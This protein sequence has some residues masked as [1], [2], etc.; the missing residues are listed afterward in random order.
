M[1][2]YPKPSSNFL[3]ETFLSTTP[4]PLR[5][6]E[7]Y[8]DKPVILTQRNFEDLLEE[9]LQKSKDFQDHPTFRKRKV[10]SHYLRRGQGTLC[11]NSKSPTFRETKEKTFKGPDRESNLK[12]MK[13]FPKAASHINT[14]KKL[15]QNSPEEC[16]KRIIQRPEFPEAAVVQTEQEKSRITPL[17]LYKLRRERWKTRANNENSQTPRKSIEKVAELIEDDKNL[18]IE[19]LRNQLVKLKESFR[20]QEN[21]WFHEKEAMKAQIVELQQVNLKLQKEL[22]LKSGKERFSLKFVEKYNDL[23]KQETVY[24]NGTKRVTYVNGYSV[25]FYSNRDVREDLLDGRQVYYFFESGT[26]QV[27]HSDGMKEVWFKNGQEERFLSNGVREIRFPDGSTK[28]VYPED[29]LA[30]LG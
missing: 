22:E 9:E 19:A 11:T 23:E 30:S 16:K 14:I 29:R 17:D 1:E 20:K 26:V 15:S 18:Q 10:S 4:I 3:R 2:T 21:S 24:S 7:K 6:L 13:K 25:I 8:E 28:T 5:N 12:S 27:I